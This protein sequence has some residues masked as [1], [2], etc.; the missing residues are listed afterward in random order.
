MLKHDRLKLLWSL[1]M[2]RYVQSM[3]SDVWVEK[4]RHIKSALS[5]LID[6]VRSQLKNRYCRAALLQLRADSSFR[7]TQ[8]KL[9]GENRT[10]GLFSVPIALDNS[11]LQSAKYPIWKALQKLYKGYMG[12]NPKKF[13]ICFIS[14][15]F[16]EK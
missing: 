12:P 2:T 15:F 10:F 3:Q 7:T 8:H 11:N 6:D 4:S 9:Q 14:V 13:S 1:D 16:E 5:F